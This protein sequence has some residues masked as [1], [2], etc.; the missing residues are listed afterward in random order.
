MMPQSYRHCEPLKGLSGETIQLFIGLTK[1]FKI[2][3]IINWLDS[4]ALRARNDVIF[5]IAEDR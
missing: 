4:F 5:I 1:V 3:L 2:Y